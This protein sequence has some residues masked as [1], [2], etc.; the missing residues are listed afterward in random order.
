MKPINEY[1]LIIGEKIKEERVKRKMSLA[2]AGKVFGVSLYAICNYEKGKRGMS[3]EMLFNMLNYYEID[4]D[5][6]VQEV[7]NEA[8]RRRA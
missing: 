3:A 4:A 1:D 7:I 2:E 5:A 6:F 8:K